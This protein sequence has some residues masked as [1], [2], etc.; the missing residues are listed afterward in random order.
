MAIVAHAGSQKIRKYPKTVL[1]QGWSGGV[2][3]GGDRARCRC[4]SSLN[5]E[6][7]DLVTLPRCGWQGRGWMNNLKLYLYQNASKVIIC[8][9]RAME[10]GGGRR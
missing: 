8:E 9:W 6:D 3:I 10:E 7:L 5:W 2:I 1:V 4:F